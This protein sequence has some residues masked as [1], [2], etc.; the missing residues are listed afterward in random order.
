MNSFGVLMEQGV[1]ALQKDDAKSARTKLK[2]ALKFQK[3]HPDA[4]HLLGIA[5]HKCGQ[6]QKAIQHIK[7]A[8]KISGPNAQYLNNLGQI[9]AE[10]G[11]IGDSVETYTK[12]LE[13]APRHVGILNNLANAIASSNRS[14]EAIAYLELALEI[15]PRYLPSVYNLARL[16]TRGSEFEK[17][18]IL[19]ETILKED[20][21]YPDVR[22]I[23]GLAYHRTQRTQLGVDVLKAAFTI[24]PADVEAMKNLV[25]VLDE[26]GRIEEAIATVERGLQLLPDW[27]EMIERQAT[28]YRRL[29]NF[30]AAADAARKLSRHQGWK[31]SAY[32]MLANMR[33]LDAEG[34]D[35]RDIRAYLNTR[36]LGDQE[37]ADLNFALFISE[38]AAGNWDVAF[39]FLSLANAL[40]AKTRPFDIDA[41]RDHH[42]QIM[43][44]FT[45]EKL[46]D[47][48]THEDVPFSPIFI[49]GMPRSGSTLVERIIA[50]H[51]NV[52]SVGE[53]QALPGVAHQIGMDAPRSEGFA[54][55]GWSLRRARQ[56]YLKRLK[57]QPSAGSIWVDKQPENYRNIGLI[58]RIFP[59]C[60]IIHAVRNPMAMR[61]SCFEQRFTEGQNFSFDLVSIGH[62][63]AELSRLMDYWKSI[64]SV[65][66]LDVHYEDMIENQ[67]AMTERILDFC[68]LPWNDA[69]LR[70]FENSGEVRTASAVQVRQHLYDKKVAHWQH[71]ERHLE[72]L[73]NAL[74]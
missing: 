40:M 41:L 57:S 63:F 31:G 10:A 17:A 5:E 64:S 46:E 74:N 55:A 54:P 73:R 16:Y 13:V 27:P 9:E 20:Q 34:Y 7:R 68:S 49:V 1:K 61:L 59:D 65:P 45:R 51:P 14:E 69:C 8:V 66:I 6:T 67:R 35:V 2:K 71:Y 11:R 70:F 32:L 4:L 72:P 37:K 3:D 62:Y 26:S 33:C 22:T 53:S 21:D 48:L 30:A 39:E 23:L 38:D 15:D 25:L 43:A 19:C 47:T 18:A 56:A 42:D 36:E 28:L 60:R 58:N 24:N 29:G 50:S 12:A 52:T 44:E